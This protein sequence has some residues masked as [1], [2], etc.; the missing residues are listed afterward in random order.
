MLVDV[1][2]FEGYKAIVNLDNVLA[3]VQE[4]TSWRIKFIGG[5]DLFATSVD[6]QVK[7]YDK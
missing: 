5:L 1:I 7:H 2:L 6:L 3:I 4:G